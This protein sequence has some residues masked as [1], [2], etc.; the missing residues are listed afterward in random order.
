MPNYKGYTALLGEKT[1]STGLGDLHEGFDM[2]W[3]P[4][5]DNATAVDGSS[6]PRDGVMD[7][8]NVWPSDLPGFKETTLEY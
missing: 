2:G 5:I 4:K 3:E 6:L 7:G 8:E 1:D